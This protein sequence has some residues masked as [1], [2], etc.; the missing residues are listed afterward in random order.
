MLLKC[1]HTNKE[2]TASSS[3]V[4]CTNT[5]TIVH[6]TF[7]TNIRSR[8]QRFRNRVTTYLKTT[9]RLGTTMD[10]FCT[11][12][13]CINFYNTYN[14]RCSLEKLTKNQTT[15]TPIIT[16]CSLYPV[17]CLRQV[18]IIITRVVSHLARSDTPNIIRVVPRL[19]RSDTPNIVVTPWVQSPIRPHN[20]RRCIGEPHFHFMHIHIFNSGRS[21]KT[22]NAKNTKKITD[23]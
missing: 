4:L 18:F 6:Y 9:Y 20:H 19:A 16:K 7:Q 12:C 5:G 14:Q 11:L 8:H 21:V 10:A 13:G 17:V 22:M 2:L 23:S 3:N 1:I 15:N